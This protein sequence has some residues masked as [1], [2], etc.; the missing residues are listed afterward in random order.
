[1]A[2]A[3]APG[4]EPRSVW[5]CAVG[6]TELAAIFRQWLAVLEKLLEP[7]VYVAVLPELRRVTV[8]RVGES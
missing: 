3:S 7:T 6:I 8:G 2:V 1:M 5:T 4:T